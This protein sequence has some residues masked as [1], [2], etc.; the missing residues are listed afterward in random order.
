ME[1]SNYRRETR[2]KYCNYLQIRALQQRTRSY[3]C[4]YLL[5]GRIRFQII[6]RI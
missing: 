2:Q 6:H 5:G 1:N 3:R 4:Y